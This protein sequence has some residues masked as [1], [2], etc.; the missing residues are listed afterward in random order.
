LATDGGIFKYGEIWS[1]DLLCGTFQWES[2]L[3]AHRSGPCYRF[4]LKRIQWLY[5][6]DWMDLSW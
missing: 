5:S 1:F 3:Y 4:L 2:S 6:K